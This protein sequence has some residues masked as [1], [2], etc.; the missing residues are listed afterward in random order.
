MINNIIHPDSRVKLTRADYDYYYF[1]DNSKLPV[2]N[3]TPVLFSK[4]SIFS[5]QDIY[6]SNI[7]TQ[8]S[9][10]LDT[11]NF[12]NFIRRKILPSLT[13]DF[14]I[15]KRYEKIQKM[16]PNEGVVLILGAGEK[17]NY[18]KLKFSNCTVI[19]SDVHDSFKPDLI[20]DGHA[21]PFSDN[22]FDLVLAAQVIEHVINPWVFCNEIQRVSKNGGLIQ[23]EAPQNF[24]YHA[25]PYDFFRF[26]FTGLRSLFPNCKTIDV[27]ITE[28]NAS[29]V[30]VTI[31][32]YLVNLSSKRIIRSIWLFITYITLG[33]L[34]YL[35]KFN[36]SVNRRS[37][38]S[39]KGFAFTFQKDGIERSSG[40]LLNDFYKLQK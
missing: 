29:M 5:T 31:S 11:S 21:I 34:K 14:N 2:I 3:G 24:P 6:E 33:W 28:G 30:A 10:H 38:T 19:T 35:D 36:L 9:G 26:T 16:L 25:E 40:E 20:F 13:S 32:N 17:T 8:N 18:Y 22:T 4:D 23:I 37:V 39:P 15:E 12:R 7:T 27:S 1:E